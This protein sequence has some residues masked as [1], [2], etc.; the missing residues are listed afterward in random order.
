ML[1]RSF[2]FLY[3]MLHF[4]RPAP[5]KALK[6]FDF[7]AIPCTHKLSHELRTVAG[8]MSVKVLFS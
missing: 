8:T 2:G 5:D 4:S 1:E 7:V 6:A 3:R